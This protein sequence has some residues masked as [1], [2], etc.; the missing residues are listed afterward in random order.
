MADVNVTSIAD[1]DQ[2]GVSN[3]ARGTSD[4]LVMVD[5]DTGYQ[6]FLES[7]AEALKYKKTTNGGALWGSAVTVI[8]I[9]GG[10][11]AGSWAVWFDQGTPGDSG[12]LIHCTVINQ[13]RSETQRYRSLDTDDDSLGTEV[14]YGGGSFD[15]NNSF[16]SMTKAIGGNLYVGGWRRFSSGVTRFMWRSTDGGANWTIRAQFPTAGSGDYLKLV[17]GN[18]TDDQDVYAVFVNEGNNTISFYHYDDSADTW[19]EVAMTAMEEAASN[20]PSIFSAAIQH[21]DNHIFVAFHN[22]QLQA[23]NDLELWEI[24]DASTVAKVADIVTDD[25]DVHLVSI[26][27]DQRNDDK[28][29]AYTRFP[30]PNNVSVHY[31]KY[32]G[33]VGAERAISETLTYPEL[34]WLFS[35]RSIPSTGGRVL[36]GWGDGGGEDVW[37]SEVNSVRTALTQTQGLPQIFL[38]S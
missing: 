19:T 6:F 29:I 38:A 21:S 33:S 3:N 30:S 14:G 25:A 20:K 8:A 22:D 32:D 24:T 37:V 16:L 10:W 15:A 28:Y 7:G 27:I 9:S 4:G 35:P 1:H 11:T 18:E 5:A 23:G 2:G 17:P 34:E 12:M 13:R 36:I 31:K 26:A